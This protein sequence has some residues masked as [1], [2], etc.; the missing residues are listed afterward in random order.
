MAD[1]N[2][3]L[4]LDS[5]LSEAEVALG[6]ARVIVDDLYGGYLGQREPNAGYLQFYY[7]NAHLKNAI[8]NDYLYELEEKLKEVRKFVDAAVQKE[9]KGVKHG[10]D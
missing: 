6:K 2:C 10:K 8:V 7:E 3:T 9:N 1:I 4:E 5:T